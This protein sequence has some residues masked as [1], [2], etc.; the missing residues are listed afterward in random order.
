M[1]NN[2][3]ESSVMPKILVLQGIPASGKTTFAKQF[4]K[5]N[6]HWIRVNRDDIRRMFGEYWVPKREYLVEATEYAIAEEAIINGWNVIVDDT[7]LN[8][9]YIDGWKEIAGLNNCEIEFKEFKISL[10]E[11]LKRDSEREN[12][13]GKETVTRFYRKYYGNV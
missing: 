3:I 9:I 11:A 5:D 6:E 12:P 10:E 13:V 8:P 4:V 2:E 7:N 1:D